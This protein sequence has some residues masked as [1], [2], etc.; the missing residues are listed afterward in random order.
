[1]T[2][3]Q[4]C[5]MPARMG[6]LDGAHHTTTAIATNNES[7]CS[8]FIDLDEQSFHLGSNSKEGYPADGE[9]PQRLASC[10]AF[11]IAAFAVTNAQF[12][13]FISDT[14]YQTLAE[15]DG[16]SFVFHSFVP[17]S[18]R[19]SNTKVS[20]D[21]P[22]WIQVA[23]AY[24]AQPEGPSSD[25]ATRFN[26]PVTQVSWFDAKAYC[27]WSGTRLPTEAEWEY[28]ARGG[29]DNQRFAWGNHL[30]IGNRHQ[31]N[32]W[33]GN[34][35]DTNTAEDGYLNTAP[36]D[37][38]DPNGFGLYN[39]CGNVWE[40]CEDWFSPNYHRVTPSHNPI[41]LIPTGSRSMRGGSFL[42]HESYCHRYRVPAR[43]SNTPDS[44]TNHCGFRVIRLT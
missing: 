33:Q 20:V 7:A 8:N 13:Q 2:G 31:C 44:A 25:I 27:E 9:G 14:N 39:V 15:R 42:C 22:W 21:M 1:M 18:A 34:F 5:C 23:G 35:P 28:A 26:H 38:F 10:S 29:L 43:N 4:R 36:V 19:H 6:N 30:T 12:Q 41:Y 16:W 37:A 3:D 40:W 11:S 17:D 24:W 32:I